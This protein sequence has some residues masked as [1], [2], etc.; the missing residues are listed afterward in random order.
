MTCICGI[1]CI[2]PL[3]NCIIAWM[4]GCTDILC[5]WYLFFYNAVAVTIYLNK[6]KWN[7]KQN[8]ILNLCGKTSLSAS[9][10]ASVAGKSWL[11]AALWQGPETRI[12]NKNSFV[13]FPESAA[14]PSSTDALIMSPLSSV[15]VQLLT[16]PP[17]E[18]M[19]RKRETG[20]F[21]KCVWRRET[22]KERLIESV[23]VWQ[24]LR[25]MS[26]EIE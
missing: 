10:S 21:Q 18:M 24:L 6:N 23:C 20:S 1:L 8:I 25:Q 14:E 26:W 4:N 11:W 3:P 17:G 7:Y 12:S 5:E 19:Q 15:P 22:V 2:A 9:M 16:E 13:V